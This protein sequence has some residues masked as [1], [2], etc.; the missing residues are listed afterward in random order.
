[1]KAQPPVFRLLLASAALLLAALSAAPLQAAAVPEGLEPVR[2]FNLERY[3]GLWYEI[4]RLDH[5]VECGMDRVTAEDTRRPDGSITVVNRGYRHDQGASPS[6]YSSIPVRIRRAEAQQQ[7]GAERQ[8]GH[9]PEDDGH[10][11]PRSSLGL[12]PHRDP[13]KGPRPLGG[14]D[15]QQSPCGEERPPPPEEEQDRRGEAQGHEGE[16]AG[17]EE[18]GGQE[19]KGEDGGEG[20]ERGHPHRGASGP[21]GIRN[22]R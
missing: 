2:E 9:G 10:P 14:P 5:S 3:L 13:H 16:P 4:A 22:A 1:M 19:E 7:G 12:P 11:D 18:V 20:A 8:Q 15:E 6:K 17:A 21:A